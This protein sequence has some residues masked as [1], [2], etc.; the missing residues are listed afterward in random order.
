MATE[1]I[2]PPLDELAKLYP[3][4]SLEELKIAEENLR[5]FVNVAVRIC[6]QNDLIAEI[7]SPAT[8]LTDSPN[9]STIRSKEQDD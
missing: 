7:E 1:E 5:H 6:E 2:K 8:P 9:R 4:L 3:N